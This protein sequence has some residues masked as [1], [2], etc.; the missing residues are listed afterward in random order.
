M[1]S[2]QES[3]AANI[4]D[5]R[6]F[7]DPAAHPEMETLYATVSHPSLLNSFRAQAA[8]KISTQFE[9]VA[10]RTCDPQE[11]LEAHTHS[12]AWIDV[13]SRLLTS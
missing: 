12:G 8:R 4:V 13:A 6:A 1:K 3:I 10:F 11:R 5:A 7:F 2:L 9:G